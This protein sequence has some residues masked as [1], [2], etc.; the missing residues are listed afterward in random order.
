MLNKNE[1]DEKERKSML[2]NGAIPDVQSW[3]YD[4]SKIKAKGEVEDEG[5]PPPLGSKNVNV[6][7][8]FIFGV[9]V[10]RGALL[11][12]PQWQCISSFV[13][14]IKPDNIKPWNKI[15]DKISQNVPLSLHTLTMNGVCVCVG[16]GGV[17]TL[18]HSSLFYNDF[19]WHD[20]GRMPPDSIYLWAP[21]NVSHP[22]YSF[23]YLTEFC[24]ARKPPQVGFLYPISV[25]NLDEGKNLY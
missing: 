12:V 15:K 6:K 17:Q 2:D 23:M 4:L 21:V 24:I 8:F 3:I 16:G 11:L 5:A 1:I 9:N 10:N 20:I 19:K 13:L 14:Y 18:T 25:S 7:I 22:V